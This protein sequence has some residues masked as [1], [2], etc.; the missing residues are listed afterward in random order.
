MKLQEDKRLGIQMFAY[1]LFRGTIEPKLISHKKYYL[2]VI[3]NDKAILSNCFKIFAAHFSNLDYKNS[4]I[5]VSNYLLSILNNESDKIIQKF[6]EEAE[7]MNA[8]NK[9]L[10]WNDF[11]ELAN[12]FC[13]NSFPTPVSND[14][15]LD[16]EGCGT[17]AVPTFAVWTNVIQINEDNQAVNGKDA[18]L[19]ANERI[20]CWDKI[21]PK[22]PFEEWEL[23]QELY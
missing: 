19:R 10:F 23:D 1:F 5:V 12:C 22:I 11:L 4:T 20:I 2:N 13:Y 16:L 18:L 9:E 8:N 17:D 6:I 14:Y 3:L 21:E 7:I 15:I